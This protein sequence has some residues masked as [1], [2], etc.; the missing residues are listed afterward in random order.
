MKRVV[1]EDE[2]GVEGAKKGAWIRVP[3]GR[4]Q[5]PAAIWQ[6]SGS[7]AAT[8]TPKLQNTSQAPLN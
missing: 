4:C 5:H 3:K 6:T 1:F 8:T 2:K 7:Q